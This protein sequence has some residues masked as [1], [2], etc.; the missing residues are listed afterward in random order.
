MK[1]L[2]LIEYYEPV[3]DVLTTTKIEAEDKT[4]ARDAFFKLF[5]RVNYLERITWIPSINNKR[6]GS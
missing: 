2:Y 1:K 3:T 4:E 5:P 6:G